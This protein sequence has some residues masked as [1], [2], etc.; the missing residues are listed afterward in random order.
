MVALAALAILSLTVAAVGIYGIMSTVVAARTREF[1][2]RI[3]LGARRGDVIRSVVAHGMRLSVVGV[4]AGLLA[5]FLGRRVLQ[6]VLADVGPV[7]PWAVLVAS[8]ILVIVG[9]VGAWLPARRA[10][11]VEPMVVMRGE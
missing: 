5:G 11:G 3:A 8:S 4:C 1:A 2:L 9:M 7:E 6:G 10:A